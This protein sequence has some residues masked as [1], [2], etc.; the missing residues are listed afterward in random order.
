MLAIGTSLPELVVDL[1]CIRKKQYE[2]AVGDIVG[3]C[4]VDATISISIGQLLFPTAVFVE[5]SGRSVLLVAYAMVA[6]AL[7]MLT[8][9]LREKV[10]KRA[11]WVFLGLYAFSF[12][13]L[14]GL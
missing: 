5:S 6:S 2:L 10:D 14:Y 13:L 11:S 7:V 9:A 12:V 4:I 1:T 8:L 3:S